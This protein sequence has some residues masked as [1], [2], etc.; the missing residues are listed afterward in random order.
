ME[1]RDWK[2][3]GTTERG[4]FKIFSVDEVIFENPHDGREIET[5][6]IRSNDWVNIIAETTTG[7]VVLIRQFRFG[8]NKVELEIPGGIIEPGEEPSVAAERELQEETGYKG[9]S[10]R[11]IGKVNPNPAI[12]RHSC[13]TFLIDNAKKLGE[14]E[15]DGPNERVSSCTVSPRQ[16]FKHI[17]DGIITH[18]LVVNAFFFYFHEKGYF[19]V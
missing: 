4:S 2:K 18:S 12:H 9:E 10:T 6:L 16:A 11:L 17:H 13:Y 7:E 15:F 8:S 1:I 19:P 14:P 5:F 3:K